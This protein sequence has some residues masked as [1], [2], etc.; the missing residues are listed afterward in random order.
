MKLLGGI[1]GLLQHELVSVNARCKQ[2]SRAPLAVSSLMA[3]LDRRPTSIGCTG[4]AIQRNW[5]ASRR[6]WFVSQ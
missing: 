1:A 3:L 2:R 6:R 4:T 5:A